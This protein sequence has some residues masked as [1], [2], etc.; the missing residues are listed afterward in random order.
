MVRLDWA[1]A[2]REGKRAIQLNPN[3]AFAHISYAHLLSDLGR[4]DE[5]I[6]Q[7]ERARELEPVSLII[8]ALNGAVLYY[9][10]RLEESAAR[11]QGTLELEP[12]FWVARLFLGKVFTEQLKFAEAID[13]FVRSREASQGNS[14]TIAM[15]GYVWGLAGEAAKARKILRKMLL[16]A[17]QRYIPPVN[18]AVM[19]LGLEGGRRSDGVAG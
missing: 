10:K 1:G 18:V 14:E 4:H 5:A 9:A 15:I 2:E 19:Y 7:G 12:N 8:N 16:I 11:L 17:A 6:A 3:S 13:Q